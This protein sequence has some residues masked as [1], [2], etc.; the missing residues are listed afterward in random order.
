M[1]WLGKGLT[2]TNMA[3]GREQEEKLVLFPLL[4]NCTANKLLEEKRSHKLMADSM[5]P[6]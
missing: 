5:R 3:G 1:C 6:V 2:T 4:D